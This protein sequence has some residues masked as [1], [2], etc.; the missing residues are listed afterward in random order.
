M[1][2]LLL[3]DVPKIGMA[4]TVATVADGF[5]RNF[6]FPH[7]LARE[8]TRETERGVAQ[9]VQTVQVKKEQIATKSSILAERIK[10]LTLTLRC[11]LHHGDRLYG[12]VHATDIVAL[13]A[14]EGI[15]VAKNQIIFEEAIKTKGMHSVTIKLSNTLQPRC[16]LK[17]VA[18]E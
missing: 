5:A 18:G 10:Q 15:S 12:A 2:I 17:V 16:A 6:L 4:G 7:K 3:K 8:V 14:H 13:L 9:L 1:K 11:K